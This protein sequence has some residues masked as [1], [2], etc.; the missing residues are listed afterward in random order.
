MEGRKNLRKCKALSLIRERNSLE[1]TTTAMMT[2]APGMEE[3][4]GG[5]QTINMLEV[6]KGEVGTC[7]HREG[8]KRG[9]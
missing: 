2:L 8:C 4:V 1:E 6:R 7:A 9:I 5:T 3:K